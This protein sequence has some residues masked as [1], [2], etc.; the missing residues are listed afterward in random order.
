MTTRTDFKSVYLAP[1]G[2]THLGPSQALNDPDKSLDST[3]R[4]VLI[5][6]KPGRFDAKLVTEDGRTCFVRNVDLTKGNSFLIKDGQF[7]D[8]H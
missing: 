5:G 2:S 4:L 1:E 8:C 7:T 3:E 6:L